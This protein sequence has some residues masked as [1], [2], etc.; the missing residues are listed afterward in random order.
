MNAL[1]FL[2]DSF[3]MSIKVLS[4]R[5]LRSAL[6]VA[7]IAVGPLMM[8]MMGSVVSGYSNYVLRE[9]QSLGQNVVVVFP[10]SGYD[11]SERDLEFVRSI[12]YVDSAE[13]FYTLQGIA[14]RCGSDISVYVYAINPSVIFKAM[15]NL[16]IRKGSVP[17][18]N[19]LIS[20]VVG[21][22][23]SV[24][25]E[26][27]CLDSGD[28]FSLYIAEIEGG[29]VKNVKSI[30]FV[31]SA[32]LEEY[33]G[34]FLLSPD[35]MVI[36]NT[37]SGRTMLG[38]KEWSG[39]FVVLKSSEYVRNFLR[40][41]RRSYGGNVELVSFAAIADA[42]SSIAAAVSFINYVTSLSAFAVAV[43]GVSA[44]MITSVIERT[45]E[46]GVMKAVGFT[47]RQVICMVMSES[48]VM[49]LIGATAG[50]TLGVV[51]AYLLSNVGM[52]IRAGTAGLV[53]T[54]RP[55]IALDRILT[56]ASLTISVG[57]I[58][59]LFPAYL[60]ARIPPAVALRYE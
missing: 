35:Q 60:A 10:S 14:R 20:A 4:E 55:E 59:G 6:T 51:G 30:N 12:E 15:G 44:T 46:I 40:E 39:I 8:I 37:E 16:K 5:K 53:L 34:A 19:D 54:A 47:N 45:R 50:I 26:K 21:H 24:V 58:G 27:Q 49:S 11:L 33:G 42:V 31:V 56:T 22:K 25:D 13:P 38:A 9:L 7:G 18:E 17:L 2:L 32:L 1:Q 43:A 36:V 28:V 29:K 57:L 41:M 48:L 23:V 52:T 3:T